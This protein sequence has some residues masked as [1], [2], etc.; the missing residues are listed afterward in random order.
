MTKLIKLWIWNT[1]KF[2]IQC[3]RYAKRKFGL[4]SRCKAER[5]DITRFRIAVAAFYFMIKHKQST[6]HAFN[7]VKSIQ[8]RIKLNFISENDVDVMPEL[9]LLVFFVI[10]VMIEAE[11]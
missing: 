11:A 7:R 6:H 9:L 8:N 10:D 4:V 3:I 5:D 1:C 2:Q